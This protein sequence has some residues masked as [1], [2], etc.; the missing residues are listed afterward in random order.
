MKIQVS[1]ST[2]SNQEA[3]DAINKKLGT[4]FTVFDY[5]AWEKG[6]QTEAAAEFAKAVEK[7][8]GT[9]AYKLTSKLA[10]ISGWLSALL[11]K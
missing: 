6:A 5:N 2:V 10:F 1:L 4:K 7:F 11:K 8:V 9:P 3:V